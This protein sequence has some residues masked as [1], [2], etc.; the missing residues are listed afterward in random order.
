MLTTQGFGRESRH[1]TTTTRRLQYLNVPKRSM[2]IFL[3]FNRVLVDVKT[4]VTKVNEEE[5]R[6]VG[7]SVSSVQSVLDHPHPKD[8][9]KCLYLSSPPTPQVQFFS[10]TKSNSQKWCLFV[11]KTS[12]SKKKKKGRDR[13]LFVNLFYR[14]FSMGM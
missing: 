14:N 3:R 4:L 13:G 2:R 6:H 11:E 12:L 9:P 5:G 1:S 7:G 10:R 8:S